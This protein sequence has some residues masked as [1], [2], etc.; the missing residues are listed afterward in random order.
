[1]EI[2]LNF[3]ET[4]SI[5][6]L[7]VLCGVIVGKN[8][9]FSMKKISAFN[10]VL[11]SPLFIFGSLILV[12]MDISLFWIALIAFSLMSVVSI[13]SWKTLERFGYDETGNLIGLCGAMGNSGNFGIPV[14]KVIF[15]SSIIPL[16]SLFI[17]SNILYAASV[18]Y[19][20]AG[21]GQLP[22]WK[23]F[24]FVFKLPMIHA[25]IVALLIQFFLPD[26][27]L[28]IE[29]A[30]LPYW[31]GFVNVV[32]AYGLFVI[33]L[34]FSDAKLNDFHWKFQ[35]PV[36]GSRFLLFPLLTFAF[37][38][39]DETYLHLLST[40]IHN[41]FIIFSLLPCARKIIMMAAMTDINP[42]RAAAAVL[43]TTIFATFFIPI[44][45]YIW[46]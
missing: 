40:Q 7:V 3:V 35:L 23:A 26:F 43:T 14:I 20:I 19:Y 36:F 13:I 24:K 5:L 38:W 31:D 10:E 4:L 11:L 29:L 8:I 12:E 1:M 25:A 44:V 33:G 16:Y 45:A 32:I 17:V 2:F 18:G 39:V 9:N 6:F 22:V 42:G 30:I 28:N 27:R 37:I 21:R 15:G 46:F 41:L 34:A